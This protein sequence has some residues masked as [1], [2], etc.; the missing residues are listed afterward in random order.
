MRCPIFPCRYCGARVCRPG[1]YWCEDCDRDIV[2]QYDY[3]GSGQP[4][5]AAHGRSHGHSF[6]GGNGKRPSHPG[7]GMEYWARQKAA[8]R[9]KHGRRSGDR[10]C[11]HCG[12][13]LP[14][15]ASLKMKCHQ[16]ACAAAAH[17][18]Q[19]NR[20]NAER[21]ALNRLRKENG[22]QEGETPRPGER[23]KL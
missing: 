1:A 21:Y 3:E 12:W 13:P 23:L 17:L 5:I 4:V 15:D 9:A 20:R 19:I 6:D 8:D 10:P 2:S 14:H 11:G 22:W 7:L 18:E 16:G